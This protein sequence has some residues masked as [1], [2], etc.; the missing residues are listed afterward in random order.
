MNTLE[1]AKRGI[2]LLDALV[3]RAVV[4]NSL[5]ARAGETLLADARRAIISGQLLSRHPGTTARIADP[6]KASVYVTIEDFNHWLENTGS[7]LVRLSTLTRNPRHPNVVTSRWEGMTKRD[8]LED[9][10]KHNT[11]TA[12]AK[13]RGVSRQRYTTAY[14]RA[15][16]G[17]TNSKRSAIGGC[18]LLQGVAGVWKKKT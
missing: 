7:L 14:N 3:E 12:A 17:T 8:F 15:V 1:L 13:A 18:A 4:E 16:H 2:E 5:D 9:I 10:K 6:S 11:K